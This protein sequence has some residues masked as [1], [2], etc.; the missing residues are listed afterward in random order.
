MIFTLSHGQA[1]TERGFSINKEVLDTNMSEKTIVAQR[2]I[3]DS[4]NKE[5]SIEGSKDVSKI[6]I[7]KEML[8]YCSKASSAYRVQLSEK[9]QNEKGSI[10]E[11]KKSKIKSEIESEEKKSSNLNKV[12]DRHVKNADELALRA[13]NEKK[14]GL[15]AE[16]N[17]S[18]KRSIEISKEIEDC[19]KKIKEMKEKLK[20]FQSVFYPL[21]NEQRK[22][23]FC[24]DW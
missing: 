22:Y 12:F 3:C 1:A 14:F 17:L 6:K 16:S 4:V 7:D 15:I 5:L 2:M 21:Y 23:S 20:K 10:I 19:H 8:R 18:R 13:E 9:R 24:S 11:A